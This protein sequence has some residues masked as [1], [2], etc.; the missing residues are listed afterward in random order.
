MSIGGGNESGGETVCPTCKAEARSCKATTK[1]VSGATEIAGALCG[2][3]ASPGAVR[4]ESITEAGAECA[5]AYGECQ[6]D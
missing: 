4:T 5:V 3:A 6:S 2:G 1:S